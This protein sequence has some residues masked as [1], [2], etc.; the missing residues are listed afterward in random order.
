MKS[1]TYLPI[2]VLLLSALACGFPSGPPPEPTVESLPPTPNLP[3]AA[4]PI[5]QNTP[6]PQPSAT[7]S[8][9]KV[10]VPADRKSVV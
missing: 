5:P 1:K 2:F 4:S 8:T 3:F 6:V 9:F 10:S 7:E